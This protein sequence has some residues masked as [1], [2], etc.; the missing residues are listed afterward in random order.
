LENTIIKPAASGN[1]NAKIINLEVSKEAKA[2]YDELMEKG[3]GELLEEGVFDSI[4]P[5]YYDRGE[6]SFPEVKLTNTLDSFDFNGTKVYTLGEDS[7]D[8]IVLFVHGGAWTFE[9]DPVHVEF[10]DRLA[11]A[12]KAKV[13]MPLYP[14]APQHNCN[15]TYKV[16]SE[17]YSDLAKQGKRLFVMGDSAG[18]NIVLGLMHLIKKSG[19]TMPKAIALISPCPDMTFSDPEMKKS[20]RRIRF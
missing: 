12:M 8:N 3:A 14:L 11:G 13:Y 7:S 1:K 10:C 9:I 4:L 20:K 2:M 18:A 17:L 19:G 5:R 15:D 6:Q 16:I